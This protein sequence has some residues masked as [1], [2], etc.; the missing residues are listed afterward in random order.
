MAKIT[1][2]KTHASG[3]ALGGIGAGSTE[4]FP[5]G[6]FHSWLIANQP[7]ITK[8][9]FEDKVDDGES[10]TG[11]LSFYVREC[12]D[13][14]KPVVRKLGMKTDADDFTYRM[15]SWNKPIESIDFDG[16][17]PVADLTY[18][19]SSLACKLK[20]RAV[21]PFVP[22][23]SDT[24]STP[25]FYMDFTVENPTDNE[26]QISLLGTLV[27][28]VA[29][30]AE[31]NKNSL[32]TIGNGVGVHIE[33]A[34]PSDSP[35]CGELCFSLNG[36][37]EKTCIT[38]DYYRFMREFIADS[39]LGISQESVLFGF[40]EKGRLPDT[41]I[42]TKPA[43]LPADLTLLSDAELDALCEECR[44]YPFA[45]SMLSRRLH[46]EPDFL[47]VRENK[48]LFLDC[49]YNQ[50]KRKG[51]DF[52]AC[53]L[54]SQI[55]LQAGEKKN[56][57]FILTWY[58]PNHTASDG[59]RIGHYYENLYDGALSANR[60]LA[61]N[62]DRIAGDA[63]A[64]AD[65]LYST[66]LPQ[67]YP[68]AWSSNLSQL[69]KDSVYLKNGNFGLWEGLGFCGLHTTDITYHASFSLI[70]LF[71]D[72][73]KKQMQMGAACQ[74][75]DGRVHHCFRPDMKS[76]NNG[77]SRVDISMQ[78][79][80]M[81]LRD[82]LFTGDR[83]YLASLWDHVIR[84]MD[85][86]LILDANGDGLPDSDT[87]RN[88][89]DAWNFSGTPV[90]ISVLWLAALKAAAFMAQ[91][92]GDKACADKWNDLLQKGK[93]ALEEKLWNGEYYDLWE[94]NGRTDESLMTDQLDGEWFLRM[95]GLDGNLSDER[96][97]S[98]IEFIFRHNFDEEQGL[99][100]A[101]VPAGK[102]TTVET[103][104]NCQTIAVWTG[105]GYA[106][107]ALAMSV[108]ADDISDAVIASIHNN[109][110]RFGHFWDHWECGHHYTRPMS[111]WSTLIAAAGMAVDYENKKLSF[112]PAYKNITFPLVL[113]DIL[114]KVSFSDGNMYVE[115][116][117]G[118]LGGWEITVKE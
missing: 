84:A 63:A 102:K 74:R 35:A 91:R 62:H 13:G 75:E 42:G 95:T 16:R 97:R 19:D 51:T 8:V 89:Y 103:Y 47:S 79:V 39:K 87:K 59:E 69:I 71:P 90:Y 106:F 92:V 18:N 17:F 116:L 100:N 94:H 70:S 6:E 11:S 31:G 28:D 111:S 45:A 54:C 68:D 96:V 37:G 118:D 56:I 64:F 23:D 20:L 1:T 72:L 112:R 83:E 67:I 93:E 48:I 2:T 115:C 58:F 36:D 15:F 66:D 4:L 32:H 29:N 25:G 76:V 113:P 60:F 3:I 88:T 101:T 73:Q 27:P 117:K 65:L 52:G 21:S 105:I 53:A 108:H 12:R 41:Q 10:S 46:C 5:D 49:C 9:C 24:A 77:F 104:N 99:L 14:G 55:T 86:T 33:P 43:L 38:A 40:R 50:N 61:Q 78:F 109:Q 107:S 110:L 82:Y 80:L 81:V 44:K 26:L 57:R 30:H 114:A 85:A 98:V 7:R 34:E 22:H